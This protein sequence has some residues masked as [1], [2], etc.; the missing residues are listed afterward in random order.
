MAI[1][2]HVV[3]EGEKKAAQIGDLLLSQGR[4]ITSIE[5]PKNPRKI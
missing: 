1:Y 3:G 2:T 5:R 4:K